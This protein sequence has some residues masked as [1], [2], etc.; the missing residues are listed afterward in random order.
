MIW[1]EN[2]LTFTRRYPACIKCP[3][4][5]YPPIVYA[6]S[7]WWRSAVYSNV[8]KIW[9]CIMTPS[10]MAPSIAHHYDPSIYPIN[11][12]CKQLSPLV[13]QVTYISCHTLIS[14]FYFK[15]ATVN[16]FFLKKSLCYIVGKDMIHEFKPSLTSDLQ[17]TK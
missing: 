4:L 10:N 11:I 12:I 16:D 1:W 8:L 5:L 13:I 7:V 3:D 6:Q 17:S 14:T 15:F 2:A 9:R